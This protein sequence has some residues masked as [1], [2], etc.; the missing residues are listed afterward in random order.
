[1]AK[2][3]F[4]ELE[5]RQAPLRIPILYEDRSVLALD[6]PAGWLLAPADWQQ[7]RRNLQ[8]ALESA[9]AAGEWW[10]KSRNL[11]FLRFVHRLDAET[12]GAFLCVRSPGAVPAYSRLFEE[13][14][15]EKVYLA[16]VAGAPREAQWTCRLPLAADEASPGRARVDPRAG[17]EAETRFRLLATRRAEGGEAISLLEARPLTGRTH[18]IRVHLEA[19]RLPV[20]GDTLYRGGLRTRGADAFPL[21]LRSVR[22][23]YRDPFAGRPVV[24]RAAAEA[25]CA[26]YGFA[27]PAEFAQRRSPPRPGRG[28]GPTPNPEATPR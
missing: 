6:K 3:T 5:G 15:V 26:A 12:S 2:P 25:F 11:R 14:G 10:A 18:Q 20:L 13:R 21:A 1:M 19:G 8:A 16:V 28:E 17:R 22:L 24:I 27:T 23:A 7:T 4:I 9:I